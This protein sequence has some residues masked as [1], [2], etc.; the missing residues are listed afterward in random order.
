MVVENRLNL[1]NEVYENRRKERLGKQLSEQA[2]Q[3]SNPQINPKSKELASSKLAYLGSKRVEDR[4]YEDYIKR[5]KHQ[6]MQEKSLQGSK[7]IPVPPNF[8]TEATI[9]RLIDY[10]YK[11]SVKTEDLKSKYTDKEC[12]F[13]PIINETSRKYASQMADG[14]PLEFRNSIDVHKFHQKRNLV[15]KDENCT[16]KPVVCE[17]SRQMPDNRE[18]K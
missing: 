2:K 18:G 16:F 1:I 8:N 5:Q 17:K 13:K 11:Y 3:I 4:L 10:K 6:E 14:I 9:S 7:L 15:V 12:T